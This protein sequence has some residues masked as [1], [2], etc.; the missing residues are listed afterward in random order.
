MFRS[1]C[2]VR[3]LLAQ[4]HNILNS[5]GPAE[6]HDRETVPRFHGILTPALEYRSVV[7]LW[8]LVALPIH[9]HV[10]AILRDV[11][12]FSAL[13]VLLAFPPPHLGWYSLLLDAHTSCHLHQASA[14]SFYTFLK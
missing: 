3:S 12:N 2:I 7:F 9:A 8:L 4:T 1:S 10:V 5:I 11:A 14:T 6:S 13:Q